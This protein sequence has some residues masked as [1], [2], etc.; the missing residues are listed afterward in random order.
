M[1]LTIFEA[2]VVYPANKVWAST[3]EG[4]KDYVSLKCEVIDGTPTPDNKAP[5]IYAN[6]G[7][8]EQN[9]LASYGKGDP[10]Q[11]A[12][13]GKKWSLIG[14]GG[15]MKAA[16]QSTPNTTYTA[17]KKG[18][19]VDVA[20]EYTLMY[21]SIFNL[22]SEKLPMTTPADVVGSAASTVFIALSRTL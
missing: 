11:V 13:D 6:V 2:R 21:A 10:V 16:A 22:L 9:L 1:S 5:V 17:P 8:E 20:K 3:K 7:S 14:S 12:H 15:A 19:D 4:G 18:I